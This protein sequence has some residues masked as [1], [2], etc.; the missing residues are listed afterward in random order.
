LLFLL[1]ACLEYHLHL[2]LYMSDFLR[3]NPLLFIFL[4]L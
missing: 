2:L 1:L 4:D 3:H